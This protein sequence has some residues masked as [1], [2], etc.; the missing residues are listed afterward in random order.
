[1]SAGSNRAFR[2]RDQSCNKDG[3]EQYDHGYG[4]LAGTHERKVDTMETRNRQLR[5]F[6]A[7]CLVPAA[8][9][10]AACGSDDGNEASQ[11]GQQQNQNDQQQNQ[12]QNNQQQNQ[13][14]Q[15]QNQNQNQQQQK[16]GEQEGRDWEK[17]GEEIGEKYEKEY[18]G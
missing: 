6:L 10:L 8:I 2:G 4:R 16:Q 17:K 5:W 1:M 3:I 7:L 15:Q 13:N 11:Q 12:N 9:G 14:N 18:G